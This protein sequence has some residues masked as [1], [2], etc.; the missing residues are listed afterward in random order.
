MTFARAFKTETEFRRG[1]VRVSQ[2]RV[3]TVGSPSRRQLAVIKYGWELRMNAL[4]GDE[5]YEFRFLGRRVY[6]AAIELRAPGP[7]IGSALLT[8]PL[9]T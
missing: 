7:E 5:F 9:A 8:A 6:L 4:L 1:S 2:R 3:T